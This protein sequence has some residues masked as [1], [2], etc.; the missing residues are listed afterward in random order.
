[1]SAPVGPGVV[2]RGGVE[3]DLKPPFSGRLGPTHLCQQHPVTL[4]YLCP[5]RP[6][7][8]SI[9]GERDLFRQS[10]GRLSPHTP[11][12]G[13]KQVL[14]S[15]TQSVSGSRVLHTVLSF[16]LACSLPGAAEPMGFWK[17]VQLT[18]PL[19][20]AEDFWETT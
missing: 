3:L 7:G 13:E 8:R 4:G 19:H 15:G 17:G 18:S 11:S 2:P 10:Q 9:Q 5:V 1:M 16:H 14:A 12:P 6:A 20:G